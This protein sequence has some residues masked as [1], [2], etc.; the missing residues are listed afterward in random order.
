MAFG[1]EVP[2][3]ELWEVWSIPLLQLLSDPLWPGLVI[4]ARVSSM[5]LIDLFE[6]Y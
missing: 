3:L 2:V 5:A 6:N 4:P 1:A